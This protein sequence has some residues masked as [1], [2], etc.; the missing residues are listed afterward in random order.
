[1]S[2]DQ[3]AGPFQEVSGEEFRRA[4]GRFAAGVTIATVMDKSGMPHGVTVSSFTSV[5]LDPPLIL[6]CLGHGAVS[7]RAFRAAGYFGISI[8]GEN[9]RGLSEHF[10]RKAHHR[11]DGLDWRPGETGAP[12]IT[13][14][15]AHIEC[16][17]VRRIAAGDHDIFLG[18]VVRAGVHKGEPLV[19]F[20]SRYRRLSDHSL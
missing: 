3:P 19:N 5:S 20:A 2:S 6:I 15:L 17:A 12:L 1:M 13:G 9:Q 8:L 16:A 10:A 14:A 11:F 4:C 18:R 7:L